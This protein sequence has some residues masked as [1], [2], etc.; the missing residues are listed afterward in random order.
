MLKI[1]VVEDDDNI[2]DMFRDLLL[3]HCYLTFANNGRDGLLL[4]QEEEFDV[5]IT[6][7]VMPEMNGT[8]MIKEIRKFDTS[9]F[10]VIISGK[11]SSSF[12]ADSVG[13]NYFLTKPF[14][15]R[16]QGI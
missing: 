4:A 16:C 13:A 3:K 8:E 15:P 6:D 7:E 9:I 2:Q 11:L 12:R 5:I 14:N 10:V 1:L